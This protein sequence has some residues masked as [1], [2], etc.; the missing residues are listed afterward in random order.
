MPIGLLVT[1][2]LVGSCTLA[3]PSA[4]PPATIAGDADLAWTPLAQL[5]NYGGNRGGGQERRAGPHRR[6][7]LTHD[8]CQLSSVRIGRSW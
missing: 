1:L 8:K 2:G 4:D 3:G 6:R 7:I 5:T